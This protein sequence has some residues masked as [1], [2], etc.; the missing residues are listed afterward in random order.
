MRINIGYCAKLPIMWMVANDCWLQNVWRAMW[1]L[2]AI[3]YIFTFSSHMYM[4]AYR[5][6]I[7]LS[8]CCDIWIHRC[9]YIICAHQQICDVDLLVTHA[10]KGTV[11]S[12]LCVNIYI[13]TYM[14]YLYNIYS[15]MCEI[16]GEKGDIVKARTMKLSL[17][18]WH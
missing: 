10:R 17:R 5:M 16:I 8:Y 11:Y 12:I 14:L 9:I 3:Y 1:V 15:Y 2:V 13:Y 4:H 6:C 18:M 7:L